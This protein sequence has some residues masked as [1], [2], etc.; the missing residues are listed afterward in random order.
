MAKEKWQMWL[1]LKRNS[2]ARV[3]WSRTLFFLLSLSLL[4]SCGD[5]AKKNTGTAEKVESLPNNLT[6]TDV[7]GIR[8]YEVKRRF[9]NGLSFNKDG[10]Q[11]EPSW[12]IEVKKRDSIMVY[13]PTKKAFETVYLQFDHGKVYNFMREFFRVKLVSKDSL[14]LQRLYVEGKEIAGDDDYRSEVYSTY[15]S[16]NYIEHKLHTTASELQKPTRAD[17][18]L[19]K[20]LSE[21][22]YKDPFNEKIA[23]AARN[24]VVFT[25]LSPLITV[26]KQK[27]NNL[28]THRAEVY[29]Y[30]YPEYS[31]VINKCYKAFN[32]AMNVIV[33][34]NGKIVVNKV[35][36]V[37]YPDAKKRM[38]QGVVDVYFKNMLKVTPGKTL[39]IPHSSEVTI[40]LI[41]KL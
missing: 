4:L 24:P 41:G 5:A 22:T 14:V 19:I 16:K 34:A 36:Y 35:H 30:M 23:F 29:E 7:K 31:M 17:T 12:I 11:Q 6:L 27:K 18:L 20:G 32:H 40:Y 2:M 3:A 13:S 1:S 21:K 9:K 10:F 37:L 33:D 39:D 38:L 28:S 15:Y 26:Q 25:P 8:F